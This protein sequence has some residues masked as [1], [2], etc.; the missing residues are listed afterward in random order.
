M[1]PKAALTSEDKKTSE[2]WSWIEDNTCYI[3]SSPGVKGSAKIASFD[4][5]DTII[6]RKS[7]AK[8]PKDADD[9]LFL[10]D[11]VVP[12]IKQLDQ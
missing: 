9:W 10:N 1:P 3:G 4:M 7:G 12:K 2:E 11:K 8:F 6:T 5:D